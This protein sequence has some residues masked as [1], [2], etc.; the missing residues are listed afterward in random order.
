MWWSCPWTKYWFRSGG[1]QAS[2]RNVG[3]MR[4][5]DLVLTCKNSI[6]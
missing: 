2:E 6:V 1:K 4:I 5:I 3:T